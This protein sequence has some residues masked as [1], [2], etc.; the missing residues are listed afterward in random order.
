M[1]ACWSNTPIIC[2]T[3]PLYPGTSGDCRHTCSLEADKSPTN[4]CRLPRRAGHLRHR[5][6]NKVPAPYHGRNLAIQM[7]HHVS[8]AQIP[9]PKWSP[10]SYGCSP[11]HVP[12]RQGRQHAQIPRTITI[13]APLLPGYLRA[14]DTN[15]RCI[16][17]RVHSGY[18]SATSLQVAPVTS[19]WSLPS[20]FPHSYANLHFYVVLHLIIPLNTLDANRERSCSPWMIPYQIVNKGCTIWYPGG[21]GSLLGRKKKKKPSPAVEVKKKKEKEKEKKNFT[22][23]WSKKKKT[24]LPKAAKNKISIQ[25]RNSVQW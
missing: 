25:T 2:I 23:L 1:A 16:T 21:H 14:G 24:S 22:N 17:V 20:V 5:V 9:G 11:V 18:S 13:S 19:S 10:S 8:N 4:I 12:R 15:D 6:T 7:S 3:S